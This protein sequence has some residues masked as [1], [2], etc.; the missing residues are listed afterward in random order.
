MI[1]SDLVGGVSAVRCGNGGEMGGEPYESDIFFGRGV[2]DE[3][4]G[5]GE[6]DVEVELELG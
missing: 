2:L 3:M 6:R 4:C 5:A 1:I